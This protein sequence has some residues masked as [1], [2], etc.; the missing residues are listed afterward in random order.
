MVVATAVMA[1]GHVFDVG[2]GTAHLWGT[3]LGV[4]LL[5]IDLGLVALAV[6]AATGRRGTALGVASAVAAASYLISS[7]APVVSWIRPARF[8]SLF[9]WSVGDNQLTSG[10]SPGEFGVL[11]A[12]G[13]VLGGVAWPPSSAWTCTESRRRAPQSADRGRPRGFGTICRLS[14]ASRSPSTVR[15]GGARLSVAIREAQRE[16]EAA[17]ADVARSDDVAQHFDDGRSH[18]RKPRRRQDVER[19]DGG[20]ATCADRRVH[21]GDFGVTRITST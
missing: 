15:R 4:L 5:G 1:L 17:Q 8:A 20:R 9:Y 16:T 21:R 12:A 19:R 6:G 2:V 7:L 13:L 18:P 11:V 14:F 10:L 3:S